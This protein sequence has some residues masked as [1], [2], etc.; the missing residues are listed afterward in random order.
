MHNSSQAD[1]DSRIHHNSSMED[2][3]SEYLLSCLLQEMQSVPNPILNKGR[4]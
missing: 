2:E 1:L 3:G 4:K